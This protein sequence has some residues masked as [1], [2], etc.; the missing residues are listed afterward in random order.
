MMRRW[1]V[2]RF[3]V[4]LATMAGCA[5]RSIANGHGRPTKLG[6]YQFS[7]LRIEFSPTGKTLMGMGAVELKFWHVATGKIAKD[8]TL[9]ATPPATYS[10]NG[11][12]VAICTEN[13]SIGLWDCAS[14]RL[15]YVFPQT[16]RPRFLAFVPRT[17]LLL[18]ATDKEWALWDTKSRV[19]K[20]TRAVDDKILSVAISP[21]GK[22]LAT[23]GHAGIVQFWE[24]ENGTATN[25][26]K[27]ANKGID[28]LTY[29]L[30]GKT[31]ASASSDI[32]A[33]TI[34]LWNV[35]T[36][37]ELLSIT[38]DHVTTAL[39]FSPNRE[40]LASAGTDRTVRLW[41]SESGNL[42]TTLTGHQYELHCVAFSPDGDLLATGAGMPDA[43]G[44]LFVW[45]LNGV[46]PRRGTGDE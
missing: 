9:I 25:S 32:D 41:N 37:R 34:Q 17:P 5:D 15:S 3:F 26:V 16:S 19:R 12:I 10:S 27:P 8:L 38:T 31:L 1:K 13:G 6:G 43:P 22:Q 28:S 44:E 4:W 20:F 21:D 24:T 30:N 45:R 18:A 39:A 7:V 29:S 42:L 2:A 35:T 11:R 33:S 36:L 23:G 40:L 14:M 46:L